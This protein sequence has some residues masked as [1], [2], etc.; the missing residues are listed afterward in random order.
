MNYIL[1]Y[2]ILYYI[3][4]YYIILNYIILYYIALCYCHGEKRS[5]NSDGLRSIRVMLGTNYGTLYH[6]PHSDGQ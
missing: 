2:I 6:L 4:L 1:Y 3:V 5:G